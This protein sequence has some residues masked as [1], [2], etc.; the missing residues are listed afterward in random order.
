MKKLYIAAL[1]SAII[2]LGANCG[3]VTPSEKKGA[4]EQQQTQEQAQIQE[5]TSPTGVTAEKIRKHCEAEEIIFNEKFPNSAWKFEINDCIEEKT[6]I[7]L[8]PDGYVAG[9]V[10]TC[11]AK[12]RENFPERSEDQCREDATCKMD[13]IGEKNL[14]EM[15]D[16]ILKY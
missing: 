9:Y 8:H 14:K 7:Y 1:F 11:I 6:E 5:V 10:E 2:L 3:G 15:N 4:Q 13:D 16:E 12:C